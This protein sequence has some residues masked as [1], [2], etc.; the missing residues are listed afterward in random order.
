[1]TS[2]TAYPNPEENRKELISRY[3]IFTTDGNYDDLLSQLDA[4]KLR[5]HYYHYFRH[6]WLIIVCK[7]GGETGGLIPPGPLNTQGIATTW[8]KLRAPVNKGN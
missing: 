1:M 2:Y 4:V 8:S 3:N 5:L 7:G 6:D